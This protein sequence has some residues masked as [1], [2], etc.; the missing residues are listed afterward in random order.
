M[1]VREQHRWSP[2]R[3]AADPAFPHGTDK[4]YGRGCKCTA[5][6][7]G[8]NRTRK[9]NLLRN[10]RGETAPL[11]RVDPGPAADAVARLAEHVSVVAIAHTAAVTHNTVWSLLRRDPDHTIARRTEVAL[12]AL[13]V[14]Q[15][16]QVMPD[17]MLVSSKRAAQRVRSMQA[18]GYR[19]QWL[20][21]RLGSP[22]QA[23]VPFLCRKTEWITRGLERKVDAL[24]AEIGDRWATPEN[25]GMEARNIARVRAHAARQGWHVPGAYD[26]DGNLI[27][28]AA[29]TPEYEQQVAQGAAVRPDRVDAALDAEI[30]Q[31][32]LAVR[33]TVSAA[34]LARR[35]GISERRVQ[36]IRQRAGLVDSRRQAA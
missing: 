35:H 3:I 30:V 36:R 10:L 18:L 17:H 33:Y 32:V 16:R 22:G 6:L 26:D 21:A 19:G 15:V 1:A 5:C 11:T 14:E 24:A 27:P 29:R 9:R 13:T 20:A 31:A 28:G 25:S 23:G 12:L 2:E 34:D 8:H 7:A 4:G